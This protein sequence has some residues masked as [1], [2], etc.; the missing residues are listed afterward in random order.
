MWLLVSVNTHTTKVLNEKEIKAQVL[1]EELNSMMAEHDSIKMEYAQL[2]DKFSQKDSIITSQA[3]EIQKLIGQQADYKRIKKKL[4]YLRNITQGYVHQIDSLYKVNQVLKD[5]N[6]N[7][8]HKYEKSRQDNKELQKDKEQLSQKVSMASVLKAANIS[9]SA[10]RVSSNNREKVTDRASK[11]DKIKVCL[12]LLENLVATPGIRTIYIRIARPDK[13]IISEGAEDIYSFE[14]N[15]QRLQ[16]TL[17]KDINYDN[18]AQ[19]L[20]FEWNK[21]DKS[22]EAMKGTYEVLIYADNNMIGE[23]QFALR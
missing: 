19:S 13:K 18:K 17:K 14:I 11:T 1:Q 20:C 22:K 3:S 8:T 10:I 6:I 21:K 16:F 12:T 9:V 4:E 23:A 2:A 15:G 5:E 7:I